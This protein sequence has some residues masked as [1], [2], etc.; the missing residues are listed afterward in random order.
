MKLLA[1]MVDLL[2]RT[3]VEVTPD[4]THDDI[5]EKE[6]EEEEEEEE[7]A[8]EAGTSATNTSMTSSS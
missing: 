2:H 8:A 6:E 3:L 1:P 7:E 5:I 4:A